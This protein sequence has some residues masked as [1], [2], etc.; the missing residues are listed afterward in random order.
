MR[1]SW[2]HTPAKCRI[3]K[4]LSNN[5]PEIDLDNNER[6]LLYNS[7]RS[8]QNAIIFKVFGSN[9]IL[10]DGERFEVNKKNIKMVKPYTFAKETIN[11][12][13]VD[14]LN[15]INNMN[16]QSSNF[17]IINHSSRESKTIT[18]IF[19]H[20]SKAFRRLKAITEIA[21]LQSKMAPRPNQE[22][23][24][25]ILSKPKCFYKRGNMLTAAK[26]WITFYGLMSLTL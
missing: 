7:L 11:K 10:C 24:D 8:R 14:R 17:N 19:E 22:Y 5:K 16:Y 18:S 25:I 1:N 26:M 20:N 21:N 23:N 9:N 6:K 4:E 12:G 15:P 13:W 2:N 3:S